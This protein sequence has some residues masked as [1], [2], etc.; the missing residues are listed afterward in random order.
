MQI[1]A[2]SW[3]SHGTT[4]RGNLAWT[5]FLEDRLEGDPANPTVP[6]E[7]SSQPFLQVNAASQ[8]SPGKISRTM[9]LKNHNPQNHEKSYIVTVLSPKF[10]MF[11][12]AA[13]AN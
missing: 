13:I 1:A 9:Q 4:T 8:A 7:L 10:W 3:N 2:F 12:Y 6:T 11:C 5:I